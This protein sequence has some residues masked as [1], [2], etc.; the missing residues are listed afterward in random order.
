MERALISAWCM[1][2]VLAWLF[3]LFA[4]Q[5]LAQE[6]PAFPKAIYRF[7]GIERLDTSQQTI[8]LAF[9][10]GDYNDGGQKIKRYLKREKTKAHFFFTGDF[11]RN[12]ENKRLIKALRRQGHYLGPH[13]DQHLLYASWEDRDSL[14]V[15]RAEF[16]K[17]LL[18]NY[19]IMAQFGIQMEEA[20]FF[21]PPYEWYNQQISDWTAELGLTLINFTP[22]TRS[23][24]DYTTPDMGKRYVD[25]KRIF[26]SI[27]QYEQQSSAGLNGFIL[28]IHIGT[29]PDR[30]DK[31]YEDLPTLLQ[32]LK[33]RG[34]RFELLS[35]LNVSL[36]I[37]VFLSQMKAKGTASD[38]RF[39]LSLS[40]D[41][42]NCQ[43]RSW[44]KGVSGSLSSLA[45]LSPIASARKTQGLARSQ[46]PHC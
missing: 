20:T 1:N 31:F 42:K 39:S 17:D 2:A 34:Y 23:N 27:L 32:L 18:A 45:I 37:F 46:E 33:G 29:H 9:T 3:C 15:S 26:E 11:Y 43:R 22:G 36:A 28:L 41:H 25:S 40:F 5:L 13:S 16:R 19:A 4:G 44:I 14:L 6:I 30:T 10:G 7:G 24:A 21:M 38:G 12:K 8:Y 35:K